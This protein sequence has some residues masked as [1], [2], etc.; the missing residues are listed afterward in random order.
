MN[1]NPVAPRSFSSWAY[2]PDY[3]PREVHGRIRRPENSRIRFSITAG[4]LTSSQYSSGEYGVYFYCNNRLIERAVRTGEVGFMRG[5][6][7]VPHHGHSVARGIVD[8]KGPA[9]WMPWNSS[10]SGIHYAHETFT[11]LRDYITTMTTSYATLSKRLQPV[12]ESDVFPYA[13]GDVIGHELEADE[14]I[15]HSLLPP[16][17]RVRVNYAAAAVAENLELVAGDPRKQLLLDGVIITHV[18]QKQ[19]ISRGAELSLIMLDAIVEVA[20]RDYL[21]KNLQ[22][23]VEPNSLRDLLGDI[24]AVRRSIGTHIEIADVVWGRL[25]KLRTLRRQLLESPE[26]IRETD[27]DIE[28]LRGAVQLTLHKMFRIRFPDRSSQ[29]HT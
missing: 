19:H 27:V 23:R 25:A 14:K 11:K 9:K 7:G 1:G 6:A 16:I 21:L 24:D 10:K 12:W 29:S 26:D 13:T 17:P 28:E 8:I 22:L 4:L 15:T 3:S 5:L 18:I 2:P 20:F